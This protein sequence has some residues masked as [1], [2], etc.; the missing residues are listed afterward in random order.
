[1]AMDG[2]TLYA[3]VQELRPLIGARVDKVQQPNAETLLL[4]FR[5][6]KLLC[7]IHNEHGR[8][9]LTSSVYENPEVAPSFCML[10]RKHLTN[11]RLSGIY[12]VGLDRIV[13]LTFDARNEFF[14]DVKLKLIIELM[15]KHGNAF[16][17]NED[18]KIL[19]C[20]RH[21]GLDDSA[22]RLCVPNANY[23]DP[24]T[25]QK[26]NPFTTDLSAVLPCDLSAT[27]FGISRQLARLLPQD[28][29]RLQE[30]FLSLSMGIISPSMYSFGVEPF[31][32]D[33]GKPYSSLSEAMDAFYR[34]RDAKLSMQRASTSLRAIV[35]RAHN[36]CANRLQDAF[37]AM[38]NEDQIQLNRMYGELLTSN[39][40]LIKKG[41]C[42]ALVDDYYQSPPCKI[43]IP[44]DVGLS[45]KEN[46]ARYFRKYRKAKSAC[47]YAKKQLETFKAELE[48]LEAVQQSI[49]T[50]TTTD[51]L[52]EIAL[53]L[54]QAGYQKKPQG[55][56]PKVSPTRPMQF[57]SRSGALIEVGK[58]N[59][60]NDELTRS[61][62]ADELWFHAK[63]MPASHVIL[64]STSPSDEDIFDAAFLA[65]TYSKA[66]CSN[67]VPVD[68]TKRRNVKKPGGAPLGLV[69]YTEQRTLFVTPDIEKAKEML[70]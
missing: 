1:M 21:F 15:G 5:R 64:H 13:V 49:L 50:C 47:Q 66:Q 20:M 28:A 68:Y 52:K 36:H 35:D 14:D 55:R 43:E 29:Q 12:S 30:L 19:D 8:I 40:H 60:Q 27:F 63:D 39:L 42:L 26:L 62:Q 9:H 31:L 67:Q 10:L 37:A 54:Q 16:L 56:Q 38:Q 11:A 58:N 44:L 70:K 22:I 33:G 65:A 59:K 51:E 18:G 25:Q 4:T 23:V 69:I 53:E 45:P 57:L 48:Y 32:F 6:T 2:M 17:I 3:M 61:A 46:A 41:D 7:N 34:E 24:P